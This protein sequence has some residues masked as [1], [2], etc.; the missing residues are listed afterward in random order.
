MESKT[1]A[2]QMLTRQI[3]DDGLG[4]FLDGSGRTLQFSHGR[5]NEG[6]R[7]IFLAYAHTGQVA[8]IMT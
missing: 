4:V 8:A 5:A 6:F 2:E 3:D 1:M 7:C